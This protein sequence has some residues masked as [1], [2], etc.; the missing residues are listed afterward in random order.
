MGRPLNK[1]FF[2]DP[3]GSGFQISCIANVGAGNVTAHIVSQRSNLKYLV[4]ETATPANSI[5]CKLVDATPSA[6][7]E[8]QVIITP[9]NATATVQAT[10]SFTDNGG[11]AVLTVDSFVGGYGYWA[12]GV[13]VIILGGGGNATIDYQVSNGSIVAVQLIGSPAGTGYTTSTQ[14]IADAPAANP[15][16][17]NARIINAR[18]VKNFGPNSTVYDWPITAPLGSTTPGGRA[19]ADISGS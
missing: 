3:A 6:I 8:M 2:S 10:V 1:K 17:S 11:G 4:A 13:G 18:T 5:V 16:V 12:N 7:G 19:Q 14:D 15:P 9:E